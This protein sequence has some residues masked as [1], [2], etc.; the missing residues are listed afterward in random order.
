MEEVDE[1]WDENDCEELK[2]PHVSDTGYVSCEERDQ[3]FLTK[4]RILKKSMKPSSEYPIKNLIRY[5]SQQIF[6]GKINTKIKF[7]RCNYSSSSNHVE[8]GWHGPVVQRTREAPRKYFG[9][10]EISEN[11]DSALFNETFRKN[12]FANQ[13]GWIEIPIKRL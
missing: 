2:D 11:N 13:E 5:S 9:K 6:Y 10:L 3:I 1:E 12:G 4:P 8:D 7:S